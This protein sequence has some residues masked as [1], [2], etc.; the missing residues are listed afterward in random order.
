LPVQN[1]YSCFRYIRWI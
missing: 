1:K